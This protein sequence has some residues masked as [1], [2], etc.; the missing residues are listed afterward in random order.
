MKNIFIFLFILCLFSACTNHLE[1][2]ISKEE[3][4]S[5]R[6]SLRA[7]PGFVYTGTK[8]GF[9]NNAGW[10]NKNYWIHFSQEVCNVTGLFPSGNYEVHRYPGTCNVTF[11]PN[12]WEFSPAPSP[13]CGFHPDED[14]DNPTRGY[15]YKVIEPGKIEL[16]SYVY[17]VTSEYNDLNPYWDVWAP[18]RQ[19]EVIFRWY[20]TKK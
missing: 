7:E 14:G 13:E 6:S 12:E 18:C 15:S 1:S 4:I 10:Q 17:K 8:I 20:L 2:I 11:D 16:S 5:T 3:G 9:D 19:G